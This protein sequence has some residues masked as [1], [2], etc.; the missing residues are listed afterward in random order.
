MTIE[1]VKSDEIYEGNQMSACAVDVWEWNCIKEQ[2]THT[3]IQLPISNKRDKRFRFN[4][5][6]IYHIEWAKREYAEIL[7]RGL[8]TK[9]WIEI[10]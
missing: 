3:S 10:G 7:K 1:T 5:I 8:D 4:W 6:E 2:I 9:R